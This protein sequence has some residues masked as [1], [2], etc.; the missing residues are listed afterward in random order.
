MDEMT[1]VRELRARGPGRVAWTSGGRTA[2][3]AAGGGPRHPHARTPGQAAVRRGRGGGG[4]HRG[5][6]DRHAGDRRNR[7]RPAGHRPGLHLR[8]GQR[9]GSAEHAADAIAA[10]PDVTA[11]DGQW[12]YTKRNLP[13]DPAKVRAK[14]RAKARAFFYTT[15]DSET[16]TEH[17]YRALTVVLGR[18]Y[19]YDAEGLAKI[20]RALA[21]IPGVRAAQVRDAAGRDAIALY[22]KGYEPG[23]NRNET[24]IDPSSH[25]CMG[26]RYVA[27]SYSTDWQQGD[28]IMSD[29]R[30]TPAVVDKKGEQP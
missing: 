12:I 16:R 28:V 26:S 23:G 27:Q 24:L 29:A 19:A 14:V 22:L 3:A 21:T 18:A 6:G 13:D 4:D 30:L 17:E 25:L 5:R 15:D 11:R 8:A 7:R 2:A 1:A 10:T 20:Y 9:E